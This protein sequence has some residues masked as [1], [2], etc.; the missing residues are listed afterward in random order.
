MSKGL[1]NSRVPG[2]LSL[3]VHVLSFSYADGYPTDWT[4]PVCMWHPLPFT[5]VKDAGG[6]GES[7]GA[8]VGTAVGAFVRGAIFSQ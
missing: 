6:D 2:E 4:Q 8:L 7:V 5:M 1:A 3:N